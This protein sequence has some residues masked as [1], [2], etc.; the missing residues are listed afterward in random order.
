[1]Y[2]TNKDTKNMY[3]YVAAISLIVLLSISITVPSLNAYAAS[4]KGKDND[5]GKSNDNGKGKDNDKHEK[6]DKDRKDKKEDKH[7][8]KDKKCKPKNNDKY[9][10]DCDEKK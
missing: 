2:G 8:D 7:E 9:K 10:K 3:K 1:M 6:P 4:D 5:K